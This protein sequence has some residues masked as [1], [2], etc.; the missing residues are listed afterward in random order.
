MASRILVVLCAGVGVAIAPHA[1]AQSKCG[2]DG[3]GGENFKH[4]IAVGDRIE[5]VPGGSGKAQGPCRRMAVDGK[6]RAGKSR[7]PQRAFVQ[8][9][10][11]ISEPRAVAGQHLDIGEAMVAE[12]HRLRD[13]QVREARQNG[14]GVFVGAGDLR[15][16]TWT[17]AT[18]P[19]ICE[20][21]NIQFVPFTTGYAYYG[22]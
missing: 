2:T 5:R 9:P 20:R 15:G 13:L 3:G 21:S 6:G 8:A 1:A 22:Y 10:A 7:G 18:C 11:G 4:E 12:G 19:G 14:V 16:R 17:R